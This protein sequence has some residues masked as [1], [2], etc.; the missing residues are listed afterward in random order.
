[1]EKYKY[2]FL[3]FDGVLN[4]GGK[5]GPQ[6][7]AHWLAQ[8]DPALDDGYGNRFHPEAMEALTYIIEH[9]PKLRIVISSTWRSYGLSW[10]VQMWN[11]RGYPGMLHDVT[12]LTHHSIRGKEIQSYLFKLGA[13]YPRSYWGAPYNEE[14]RRNSPVSSYVILDDDHDMFVTQRRHFVACDGQVGLTLAHAQ[15]AVKILNDG[16]I[17]GT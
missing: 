4:A 17:Y 12:E 5:R 10:L 15:R 13:F 11:N 16:I 1:M 2:L 7:E 9:V 3:D 6:R 8:Q 14:G